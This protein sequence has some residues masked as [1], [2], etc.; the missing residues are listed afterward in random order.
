ME[1]SKKKENLTLRANFTSHDDMFDIRVILGLV[2]S[3]DT[4]SRDNNVD[5][6]HERGPFI[7]GVT[8][9]TQGAAIV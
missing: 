6:L 1:G 7:L 9:D 3:Q 8:S 5:S 4:R 2:L